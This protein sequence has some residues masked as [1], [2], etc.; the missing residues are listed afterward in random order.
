MFR[1]A[2]FKKLQL[3]G[4][5][6][7]NT[8]IFKVEHI[9]TKKIYA[10]KEVEAKSLEKLNEYKEEAVQLSRAQNH[11]NVLQ[12]YGYYFYETPHNTFK[13]GIICEYINEQFN[14]EVIYRTKE[15][16]SSFWKEEEMLKMIYS[17]VDALAFLQNI[18]ICHRDIK[19]ANLFLME[20]SEIK[21][22]DFG[23]SKEYLLDEDNNPATMAT[24]RGTP[25]YLSPILWKAHVLTPGTKLVEH[26]IY[27]SDVFSTGL[28]LF[29]LTSMKDVTGFN[30]KTQYTDGEKLIK[31][32]LEKLSKKFSNRVIELLRKMLIFEEESRPNF[33]EL[34]KFIFGENYVPRVDRNISEFTNPSNNQVSSG[35]SNNKENTQLGNKSQVSKE[36]KKK[37]EEEKA[38][39]FKQYVSNNHLKFNTNKITYWFEY[40]GNMIAKYYANKD[41][42]KWKL[43][44]KYKSEF[45]GH[46]YITFVDEDYGHF[47][48]GGIDSNNAFQYRDGQITK[49]TSMN[50]DRSFMAVVHINKTILAIGGY[51]YNEKSQLS[52]I[53]TYDVEEDK[54]SLNNFE[55]LKMARSQANALLFN[56][57]SIYI[58][59]GYN[60]SYG[61]LSSIEKININTKTTELLSYKLPIPL[62]RFTSLKISET[63]I[64]LLGG[65]TR[66]CKETD[67]VYCLDVDKS[68]FSKFSP[69][70]R[71][72]I[73]DHEVLL[74]EIGQ[75]HLFFENNY[76]T[77]PPVHVVYNYL[78]FN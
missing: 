63:K 12:F 31:E 54:W 59:G 41:D 53:E 15:Q 66:L 25:Q 9:P 2:D 62:R 58:F 75:V 30:Q 21:V 64:L 45:P 71:G 44:A 20:N 43:I 11:P 27:K 49:K 50:I 23:E 70:P 40:G 5:G 65:I 3:L 68:N 16:R 34:A 39:L 72:G 52:S 22:I 28:V 47:L 60:K 17:M 67:T 1:R 7:K 74:D 77:S 35:N 69:L 8:K 6:K 48:I 24:I 42:S 10:L 26:N 46:F 78:D 37:T 56:S 51:E 61:T 73:I 13:L 36:P 33:I 76:G 4:S 32:G 29:Q 19:P 18:G 14:L 38:L 57:N 55:D